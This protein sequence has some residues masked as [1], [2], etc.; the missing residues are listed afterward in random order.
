MEVPDYCDTLMPE[1]RCGKLQVSQEHYPE[2]L[3]H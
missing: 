2:M 3:Q 1:G